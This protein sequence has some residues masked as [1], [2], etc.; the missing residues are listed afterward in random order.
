MAEEIDFSF[1]GKLA[2]KHSLDFY[3]AGRFQYGA[4]RLMV[5][6]DRFRRTGSFP[7]RITSDENTKIVL[8]TQQDGSFLIT[9]LVPFLQAGGGQFLETSLSTLWSYVADRV[10]QKSDTDSIR[11]A[12]ENER[13]LI[14]TF[15]RQMA[16]QA[17][18]NERTLELLSDRIA[19]GDQLAA[20]T[21]NLYERLIAEKERSVR[22]EGEAAQLRRI[23]PEQ[24]AKLISMAA[25]LLK[26][27]GVTLRSSATSLTISANDNENR[28]PIV[29]INKQMADAVDTTKIDDRSTLILV[30]IVQYNVETGWGKLRTDE[31]DGL[32]SFN[33]P[34]DRKADV[35]AELLEALD[36]GGNRL[37]TY[38]ECLLVKSTAGLLQRMIILSVRDLDELEGFWLA[39]PK[40]FGNATHNSRLL[41]PQTP[42][43][44]SP[45]PA[46]A[47]CRPR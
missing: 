16:N 23:S 31:A 22:L 41:T 10:F 43:P 19:A 32:L 30:R 27:M 36:R 17:N 6:M 38:V 1:R 20:T 18:Q 42:A 12:L 15:D 2:D 11:L 24:D 7:A 37:D 33:V 25:P 14:A 5:K 26:D 47:P 13:R 39:N 4:A 3:E 29:Y 21:F 8:K 46:P 9:T 28:T 45:P 35:Q 34:S 40:K 44:A